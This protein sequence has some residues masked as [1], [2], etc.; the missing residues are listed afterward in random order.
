M[1]S[2]T[3][4]RLNQGK[5]PSDTFND[6]KRQLGQRVDDEAMVCVEGKGSSPCHGDSGGPLSCLEN[7][8]WVLRG[9]ASWVSSMLCLKR[10]YSV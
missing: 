1:T 3:A 7:G 8:R 6:Y 10:K 2:I 4:G 9:S 5:A